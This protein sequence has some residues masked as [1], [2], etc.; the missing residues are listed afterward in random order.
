MTENVIRV[1][2]LTPTIGAL[3]RGVDLSTKADVVTLERIYELLIKHLVIF[4]PDQDLS[5]DSHLAFAE[6]FG[7]LDTP[8]HVYPSVPGHERIV[9]L[10]NDGERPPNTDVWHSDLTFK[11]DPPFASI[12]YS[13]VVPQ[14]GGDTLWASMYAAYEALPDDVKSHI[15]TLSAVHT[16]GS[17][18]N[19]YFKRGGTALINAAMVELGASVH[20][21]APRHPVTSRPFLYVNRHFTTH[22][23]GMTS[24]DSQRLLAYLFDHIN[25]PDF[26]VRFRWRSGTV[27]MWDNRVT[28]HYAVRDYLPGYRCMHRVTVVN[29]RRLA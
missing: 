4:L 22:V 26:Q 7:E 25:Q 6:S 12:L 28:Q 27:A 15:E 2:A 29:D 18:W 9:L 3:I 23:L 24:G 16:M 19:E 20:P 11:Q 5:P 21:I 10:E 13:K 1:D 17:Y 14:S 8:H